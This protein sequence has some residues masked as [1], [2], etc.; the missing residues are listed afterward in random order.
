MNIATDVTD[1]FITGPPG[2]PAHAGATRTVGDPDPRKVFVVHGRNLKARD[3]LFAFLG[4]IGLSPLEW[5]EAV[6]AT[7]SPNPYVGEVLDVAFSIAQAVVVLMTPDDEACLRSPYRQP[8]D[9]PH[10]MAPTPQA[11]P[12]VL[13]EAG[14]AM[15]RCPER[16]VLVELGTLRPFSDIGGRHVVRLDNSGPRRQELADRLTTAG[17]PVSLAGTVWH[18][19]GDFSCV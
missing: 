10:E 4:S 1:D 7:G 16:T 14:M 3:A 5:S 12:N 8:G 15:G 18:T 13:F 19:Q 17:C 9:P 2:K 6:K 11:R